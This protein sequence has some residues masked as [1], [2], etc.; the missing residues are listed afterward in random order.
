M[1]ILLL[2]KDK[3]QFKRLKLLFKNK[4][5]KSPKLFYAAN[6]QGAE[7]I[8]KSNDPNIVLSYFFFPDGTIFNL[9]EKIEP[10]RRKY[11]LLEKKEEFAI[12]AIRAGVSGMIDFSVEQNELLSFI[13]KYEN[14][15]QLQNLED[16]ISQLQMKKNYTKFILKTDFELHEINIQDLIM[17]KQIGSHVLCKLKSD[18]IK[19]KNCQLD[20]L[21]EKIDSSLFLTIAPEIAINQSHLEKIQRTD[22]GYILLFDNSIRLQM[23]TPLSENH[24]LLEIDK[25]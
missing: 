21:L 3:T 8:I 6:L 25:K 17:L 2:S 5:N 14:E 19:I 7:E 12:K 20:V 15:F 1:K 23:N 22:K 16:S 11:F 13:R 4:L 9:I 24:Q 10:E 18:E